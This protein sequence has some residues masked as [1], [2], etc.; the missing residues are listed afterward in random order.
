M[1]DNLI[2]ISGV[3]GHIGYRTLVEALSSGY[4][5]RAQVRNE[6][7]IQKVKAAPSVQPYLS[8]LSFVLVP[9]IEIDGAW[10]EA[11]KGTKYIIHLASPIPRSKT[12]IQDHEYE[13][14]LVNPAVRGTL[15]LLSSALKY[16]GPNLARVV[17]TASI[18]SI[19][20]WTDMLAESGI[21]Y[22][23]KS[24][25]PQPS[26]PFHGTFEA[27]GA[28][29]VASFLQAEEFLRRE[30]PS[31][32]LNFVGPTYTIG[33]NELK[34]DVAD[35]LSGTDGIVMGLILG[36]RLPD[37][38]STSVHVNDAA[39]MHI[40]A[41]DPTVAGGQIFL[42]VSNGSRTRWEDAEEIVRKHFPEAVA[43]GVFPFGGELPTKY[44]NVDNAY[45][46]KVLGIEFL[47]YEEQ[48]KSVVE[49]YLKLKGFQ[50]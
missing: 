26:G 9:D 45:T 30:K 42:G 19:V 3:T 28:S 39:K 27:Y 23:E 40:R 13:E 17:I 21:T 31:W 12:P 2:L 38:P 32:D 8:R 29:K 34:T 4:Q 22:N 47:D 1:A 14:K 36:K 11:V 7:G 18:I 6:S 41:L 24:R 20:S 5:V 37:T 49:H 50:V 48:V 43:K 15:S 33:A 44:L 16:A 46:K 25:I 10:D 35:T